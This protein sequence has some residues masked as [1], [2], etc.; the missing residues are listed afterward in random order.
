MKSLMVQPLAVFCSINSVNGLSN[1]TIFILFS[2]LI[3]IVS[4]YPNQLYLSYYEENPD[5]Y[6]A[7]FNIGEAP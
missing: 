3:Y 2:G 4:R 5:Y 1:Q 6:T 7:K